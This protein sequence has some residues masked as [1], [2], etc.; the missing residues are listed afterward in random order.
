[1]SCSSD[2]TINNDI[3]TVTF[4]TL[5]NIYKYT[6]NSYFVPENII[7][8]F[9]DDFIHKYPNIN[10]NLDILEDEKNNLFNKDI[11][12]SN[13]YQYC[14]F[15][16]N[17]PWITTSKDYNKCQ[18]VDNIKLDNKL[19]LNADKSGVILDLKSKD[20]SKTAYSPY[21]KN[22][23]KAYCENR[24][25]DWIITPNY[26]LGNTYY[27]D[28]SKYTINDVYKCY[29]PCDGD[30]LP[31]K[32]DKGELKCI[33]KKIFGNGIFANKYKFSPIGL[34]NLIGNLALSENGT[35]NKNEKKYNLLYLLYSSILDYNITNNVDTTIYEVNSNIYNNRIVNSDHFTDA[36]K[37][38]FTE[39]IFN[40]F[41]NS[42]NNNILKDF[43]NTNDQD[44][45]YTNEFTYKHK[46]FNENESEMYT[47]KGLDANNILI[48]PI[49]LHTWIL[50]NIFKPMTENNFTDNKIIDIQ[51][52]N[53]YITNTLFDNLN[54]VFKDENK[55]IRLKNIFFKA[56]NICYNNKSDFSINI[57]NQTKRIFKEPLKDKYSNLL[58][59][60]GYNTS[61]KISDIFLESNPIF[62]S[63][64]KLYTDYDLFDLYKIN[65]VN[66]AANAAQANIYKMF[67]EDNNKFKYF[68]S[69]EQLEKKTCENGYIY[70]SKIKECEPAPIKEIKKEEAVEDDIDDAFNI[71]ELMKILTIFLQIIIVII[72]LYIIYIFYDIFGETILTVYN[73]I[74]M[75]SIELIFRPIIVIKQQLG[76]RNEAE[77]TKIEAAA[78]YDLANIQVKHLKDNSLKVKE[79]MNIHN[80]KNTKKSNP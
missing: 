74:Y 70:N 54:N 6:N 18:V 27:K 29:K 36:I 45:N 78:D 57:I 69:I 67:L 40:E 26:Y 23:N 47:L 2:S 11:I 15:Q 32:T 62:N 56:V 38:D 43:N 21:A 44:Y 33:P 7:N 22:V 24:W 68:Y 34:I 37:A 20:K 28:T 1:M 60:F 52:A 12:T 76:A 39:N 71:P 14:L 35:F 49:L 79:Y 63:E 61:D 72:V 55:A 51:I 77:L 5:S 80:I 73:Y 59:S 16:A 41:K 13:V 50:A 4:N 19:K 48:S 30:Y 9:N 3:K 75:K 31:Y 10:T 17:N 58:T 25:Y 46:S 66:N 8:P 65:I 42:I 53:T 64:Y